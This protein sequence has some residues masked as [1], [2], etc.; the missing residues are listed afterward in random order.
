MVKS[1]AN[2]LDSVSE[3]AA[4]EGNMADIRRVNRQLLAERTLTMPA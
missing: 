1:T 3:S 2:T 4:V